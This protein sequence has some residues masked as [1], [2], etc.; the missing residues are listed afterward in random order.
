[1]IL[2]KKQNKIKI[3]SKANKITSKQ[4]KKEN[5]LNQV[6]KKG[7]METK[8]KRQSRKQTLLLLLR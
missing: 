3:V 4:R 1:M 8:K 6:R 5:K 7:N 2:R